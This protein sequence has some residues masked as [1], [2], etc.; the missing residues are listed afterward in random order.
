MELKPAESITELLER[1]ALWATLHR[2]YADQTDEQIREK[3]AALDPIRTEGNDPNGAVSPAAVRLEQRGRA[4]GIIFAA[5]LL[6]Q[7]NDTV[8]G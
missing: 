5:Q 3:E 2:R 7:Y 6:K 4:D 8:K 1:L